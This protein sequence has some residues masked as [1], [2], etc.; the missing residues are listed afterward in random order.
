MYY[1][2]LIFDTSYYIILVA[3][4]NFRYLCIVLCQLQ[5][6]N[7]FIVYILFDTLFYKKVN[8]DDAPFLSYKKTSVEALY[9]KT[10]LVVKHVSMYMKCNLLHINMSKCCYIHF[11]PASEYDDT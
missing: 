6:L 5:H 11:K 3:V 7:Y 10:N 1:I 8:H 2:Y 4:D 9:K